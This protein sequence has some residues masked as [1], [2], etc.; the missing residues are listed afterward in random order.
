MFFKVKPK[1]CI[2]LLLGSGILAFGLYNIHSISNITEGGIL[3]FTLLLQY[4]F[5]ISPSVSNLI[6]SLIC[7]GLGAY[8]LKKEFIV[9][10]GIATSGFSLFYMVFERFSPIYPNIKNMPLA[11]SV[12]GALFVGIGIGLCVRAGGAPGG[13]DALAMSLSKLTGKKMQLIYL[14]SDLI[15]LFLSISYIPITKLFYSLITV[16]LSGQL[17]EITANF[18]KATVG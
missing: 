2:L 7:Y 4:H 1:N 16:V 15:V 6:L 9:Y 5:G 18:K 12:V 14:I 10:S 17:I 3:G 11:A 8:V 13:D